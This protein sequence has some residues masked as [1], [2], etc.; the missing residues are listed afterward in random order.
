M[1]VEWQKGEDSF[2]R[3][4]IE[5]LPQV[6]FFAHWRKEDIEATQDESLIL[7]SKEQKEDI[8]YQ[9]SLFK[10]CMLKNT[11]VFEERTMDPD[12]FLRIYAQVAT[13]CFHISEHCTLYML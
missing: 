10:E 12:V 13:R 8:E 1:L 4:Y 3:Q 2:W 7:A 9:W 5:S 11:N 6:A